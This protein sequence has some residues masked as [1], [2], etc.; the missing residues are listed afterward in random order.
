VEEA[1]SGIN[2]TSEM[3][4]T[5]QNFIAG[6][7]GGLN[8][9]EGSLYSKIKQIV[10]NAIDAANKQAKN[11]SPSKRTMET[12]EDILM[13]MVVGM[14]NNAHRPIDV[15]QRMTQGILDAANIG[16]I[17]VG[18]AKFLT[19]TTSEIQRNMAVM[20]NALARQA[21]SRFGASSPFF[22]DIRSR[23]RGDEARE[24]GG[25][26]ITINGIELHA[27]QSGYNEVKELV[28]AIGRGNPQYTT[29]RSR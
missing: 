11:A 4:T 21:A 18:Q 5:G 20:E 29:G 9:E 27:D 17:Q 10:D 6:M 2:P 24:R 25:D 8:N 13:G 1:T 19:P 23:N 14:E 7:I 16:T 28:K 3:S 26:V 15:M 22:P 12:G